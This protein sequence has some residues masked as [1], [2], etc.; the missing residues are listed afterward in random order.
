MK[1]LFLSLPLMM[2]GFLLFAQ[3]KIVYDPNAEIRNV[4]S[5][6]AVEVSNGIN[7][8][9]KQGNTDAVAVSA[10]STD[11]IKR[12]KTEVVNAK[13][14]IYFEHEGW[15]DWGGHKNMKAYVT[16]KNI[17]ELEANSGADATTDGNINANNLR[18]TLSSGAD[19]D[20]TVT[21]TKLRVDQSSGS[22]MDIKGKVQDL[23]IETSSGS[24]FNGYGL[25][26][27]TCSAHAS[28]GSDIE[29]TVNKELQAEAS[30]GGDISYK[31]SASI[32]NVSNSSGGKIKKQS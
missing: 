17:D 11:I 9:L 32:T 13:L 7:L 20:G 28:S 10:S 14:K 21:A 15:K 29:V 4:S 1:K 25:V 5:F 18:I 26:S 8:I 12:I 31:G 22:D 27:E 30:S 3:D 2:C 24:D 6:H 23:D 19:F 16:I